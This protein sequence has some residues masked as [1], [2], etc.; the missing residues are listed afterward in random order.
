ML[1]FGIASRWNILLPGNSKIM[2]TTVGIASNII[3]FTIS[4]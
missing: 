4:Y 3:A 2:L 1:V